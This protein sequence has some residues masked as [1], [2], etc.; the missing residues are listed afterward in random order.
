[1]FL[2]AQRCVLG[3]YKLLV[4]G[5]FVASGNMHMK[6]RRGGAEEAQRFVLYFCCCFTGCVRANQTKCICQ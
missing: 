2:E 1:M 4:Y 5:A 3:F 6:V